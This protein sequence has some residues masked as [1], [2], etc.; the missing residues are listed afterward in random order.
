MWRQRFGKYDYGLLSGRVIY[1]ESDVRTY[2]AE[3]A[4]LFADRTF[5]RFR[6][7]FLAHKLSDIAANHAAKVQ[8][9]LQPTRDEY[10]KLFGRPPRKLMEVLA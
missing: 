2:R 7:P 4:A 3:D 5:D 6:N 9:R 1:R 10:E 8:V